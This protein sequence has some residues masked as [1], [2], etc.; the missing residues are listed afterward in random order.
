MQKVFGL[1]TVLDEIG[2]R[3][4]CRCECGTVRRVVRFDLSSGRSKNCGCVRRVTAAKA[5]AEASKTHGMENSPE[6]RIWVDMRRRC[7]NPKRPDYRNYGARGI[8][9]CEEWREDFAAFYRDMGP[10]PDGKT[11]D[12]LNN[13]GPYEK[14]NCVWATATSQARNRRTSRTVEINGER[15]TL[16][17]A[18]E[19][20]GIPYNSLRNRF[21]TLG[22]PIERAVSEPIHATGGLKP[23]SN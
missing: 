11:L 2:K 10:R 6:Y 22:W 12:R 13:D 4:L 23:R 21:H 19:K 8:T 9:V 7:Y 14:R 20:F 15:M 16:V 3:W 5:A 18:A 1:W 17:E